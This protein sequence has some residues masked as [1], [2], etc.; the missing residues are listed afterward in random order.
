MSELS[1]PAKP[2]PQASSAS[3]EDWFEEVMGNMGVMETELDT[4][5]AFAVED[6]LKNVPIDCIRQA[7]D[8]I[9]FEGPECPI[10]KMQDQLQA[11]NLKIDVL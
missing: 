9:H 6:N 7:I 11:E 4:W 1:F 2:I 8:S 3:S 10:L 5:L